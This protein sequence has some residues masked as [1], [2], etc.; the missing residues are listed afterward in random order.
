MFH[1][2]TS[3]NILNILDADYAEGLLMVVT[4]NGS[5]RPS[6]LLISPAGRREAKWLRV[7]WAQASS[8]A[9]SS[10]WSG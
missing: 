4:C 9:W 5:P 7:V 10:W 3:W 8:A 1:P 2:G 6:R